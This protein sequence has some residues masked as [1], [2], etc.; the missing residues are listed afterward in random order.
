MELRVP[1]SEGVSRYGKCRGAPG[2]VASNLK[3]LGLQ[4]P[5]GPGI[6]ADSGGTGRSGSGSSCTR[7]LGGGGAT[8]GASM[9]WYRGARVTRTSAGKAGEVGSNAASQP[10]LHIQILGGSALARHM[11]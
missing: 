10:F 9:R 4:R 5:W 6:G 2:D 7:S 8:T 3:P 11:T 1:W